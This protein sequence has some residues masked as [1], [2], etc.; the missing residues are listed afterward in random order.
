MANTAATAAVV[1]STLSER[2]LSPGGG[3]ASTI[4][5]SLAASST[6]PT[7]VANP[8]AGQVPSVIHSQRMSSPAICS[9]PYPMYAVPSAASPPRRPRRAVCAVPVSARHEVARIQS[10]PSDTQ[11]TS[12]AVPSVPMSA[13]KVCLFPTLTWVPSSEGKSCLTPWL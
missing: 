4:P 7:R 13:R 5:A 8:S 10:A 11:A 1:R 2:A 12:Q 9:T 6:K 3:A